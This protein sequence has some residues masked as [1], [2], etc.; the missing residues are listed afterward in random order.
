MTELPASAKRGAQAARG[1]LT[2]P[3]FPARERP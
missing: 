3:L 1:I 2:H